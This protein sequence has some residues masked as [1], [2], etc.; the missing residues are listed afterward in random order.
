MKN[1]TQSNSPTVTE[2]EL[3]GGIELDP[4]L[5][6]ALKQ[7][8]GHK[9]QEK[10]TVLRAILGAVVAQEILRMLVTKQEMVAGLLQIEDRDTLVSDWGVFARH[11]AGTKYQKVFEA[12]VQNIQMLS[13]SES[14]E[15]IREIRCAVEPFVNEAMREKRI[16]IG[17]KLPFF[18]E[19]GKFYINLRGSVT[20]IRKF[21][22]RMVR[23]I[24]QTI[25]WMA[26]VVGTAHWISW[27]IFDQSYLV[28]SFEGLAK[29][30]HFLLLVSTTAAVWV[31]ARL[32]KNSSRGG[33][34]IALL[35][36]A[37]Y[38]S[39]SYRLFHAMVTG[40]FTAMLPVHRSV[41]TR[42]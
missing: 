20:A 25:L 2:T 22:G 15:V 30:T 36:L 6:G 29:I 37:A 16:R 24:V 11:Y 10:T 8:K 9:R 3:T 4:L 14:Q 39:Q 31:F 40:R 42:G 23:R 33:W 13:P 26:V 35:R 19:F 27:T 32:A 5:D 28:A 34:P 21:Q 17:F 12:G 1:R 18:G 38:F 7:L 41:A